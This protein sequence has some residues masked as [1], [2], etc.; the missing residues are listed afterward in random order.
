MYTEISLENLRSS[1]LPHI[2]CPGCGNGIVLGAI[3]RAIERSKIDKD[4][5]VFVSGIGCAGRSSGYVNFNTLHTLHGRPLAFATGIK[6]ANPELKVIV[7]TGDGDLAAIGGNH[8]IHTAKRNIDMT[9]IVFNNFIYGMTGGQVSPTT[10]DGAYTTTT[11][12][13]EIEEPMDIS[14]LAVASGA[15]YVARETIASPFV[16][17]K[18]I[19]NGII[20]KGFSLIEAVSS[21]VTEY[22]RRNNLEDPAAYI[23]WLKEKSMPYSKVNTL[24]IKDGIVVGEFVNEEKEEFTEKYYELV[25]KVKP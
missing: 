7:A 19:L 9:V 23:K 13:G 18:Y 14:Y 6:L 5:I 4:K 24:S 1:K 21:C 2:W 11:P 10:P 16:L 8:F 12:Y 17:E 22:G 3:L 25:K 20:H 15:T